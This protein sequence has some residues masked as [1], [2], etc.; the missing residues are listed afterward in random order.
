MSSSATASPGL[1]DYKRQALKT[2]SGNVDALQSQRKEMRE[3][4]V[5][6]AISFVTSKAQS[7]PI[8]T[9]F[10]GVFFACTFFPVLSFTL[11]SIGTIITLVGGALAVSLFVS[12]CAIGGAGL[13]LLGTL[14]AAACFTIFV[15]SWA[16]LAAAAFRLVVI[17]LRAPNL[18]QGLK[19]FEAEAR[20][21]LGLRSNTPT[22]NNS[23]PKSEQNGYEAA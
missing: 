17:V 13:L 5:D 2:L 23:Q 21:V 16:I 12:A 20:H 7:Q 9:A 11:F 4:Y 8:S 10:L 15:V 14:F 6:P 19:T 22:Y 3:T 18:P 1:E